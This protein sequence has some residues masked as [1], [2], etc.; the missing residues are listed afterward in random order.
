MPKGPR[1]E[2]RGKR[3]TTE[4]CF[5]HCFGSDMS[6][7]ELYNNDNNAMASKPKRKARRNPHIHRDSQIPSNDHDYDATDVESE[8][9][10]EAESPTSEEV[11]TAEVDNA[12]TDGHLFFREGGRLGAQTSKKDRIQ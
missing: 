6:D 9:A 1:Q 8:A 12:D 4:K 5:E 3:S 2:T 11:D 10:E 7:G